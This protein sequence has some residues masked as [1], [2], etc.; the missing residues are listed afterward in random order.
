MKFNRHIGLSYY[1]WQA[2]GIIFMAVYYAVFLL[3]TRILIN[4]FANPLT[5][6]RNQISIDVV[7]SI[8]D[9]HM[10]ETFSLHFWVLIGL[11]VL[12]IIINP[13]IREVKIPYYNLC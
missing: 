6:G 4:A 8:Y 7:N 3:G 2:Y 12:Y 13:Y 1:K 11:Y 5:I 10:D 9:Y